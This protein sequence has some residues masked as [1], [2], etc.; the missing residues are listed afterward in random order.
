MPEK[1]M[2]E[3]SVEIDGVPVPAEAGTVHGSDTPAGAWLGLWG[4]CL[5]HVLLTE[6]PD[7]TVYAIGEHE[8]YGLHPQWSRLPLSIDAD[9]MTVT[10]TTMRAVYRMAPSGRLW[11]EYQAHEE[12]A[13]ALMIR[14]DLQTVLSGQTPPVW[15]IGEPVMVP[16]RLREDGATVRLEAVLYKPE[17]AGPFPLAVINHGS[18]GCGT[19]A[20]AFRLTWSDAILADCLMTRGYLA[21]FPQRRGA[22][23]V[24]GALR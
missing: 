12:V 3:S 23:T 18:T 17:G 21:A 16:T 13:S 22:R 4:G 15:S 24:G 8:E 1:P 20:A 7:T 19:D 10:G 5:K 14:H 11:A 9:V 6:P 2:P